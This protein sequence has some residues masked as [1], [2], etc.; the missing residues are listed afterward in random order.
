VN[1]HS[2]SIAKISAALVKVQ[3]TLK[4]APK[5]ANNPYFKSKYADLNSVWDAC[6]DALTGNGIAVV[7]TAR[8]DD[9]NPRLVTMLVHS[10]GEYISGEWPL[11][12]SKENDPQALGSAITYMRRYSLAAMV[13]VVSDDDDGNAASGRTETQQGKQRQ[14]KAP[15]KQQAKTTRTT[16]GD[17]LPLSAQA[18]SRL[19]QSLTELG[20]PADEHLAFASDVTGREI[21]ALSELTRAE[22]K[23]V[24]KIANGEEAA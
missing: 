13:G 24:H 1:L 21:A 23:R 5:D 16:K 2:D 22:A 8:V 9:G 7:Q 17:D 15:A 14:S 19:M 18:A 6:R 12:P 10:S 4:P 20:I 3:A 11:R